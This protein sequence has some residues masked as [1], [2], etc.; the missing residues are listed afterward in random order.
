MPSSSDDQLRCAKLW[1]ANKHL[2]SGEPIWQGE[3]YDHDRIRIAYLSADFRQHPV[4]YLTAGLFE[5][6]DRSQFEIIGVSFGIDDRS[7]IRKRIV[8][9]FDEFHDVRIKNDKEI[10]KLL[11]NRQV[12]IAI[13]LMG[14][15]R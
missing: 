10:A 15:T 9:A 1:I 14:H 3:R 13:D 4:G 5:Q 7:E 12:D 8:T 6:H 11:Y 2:P